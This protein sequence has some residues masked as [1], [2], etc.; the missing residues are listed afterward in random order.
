[1]VTR[2]LLSTDVFDSVPTTE[3]AFVCCVPCVRACILEFLK[4][5]LQL[6]HLWPT[7]ILFWRLT[8]SCLQVSVPVQSSGTQIRTCVYRARRASSTPRLRRATHVSLLLFWGQFNRCTALFLL[9]YY[10]RFC[11]LVIGKSV[12]ETPDVWKLAAIT[13]FSVLAVVL[14]G[15]ALIIGVM[16]HRRKS[17]KRPLRGACPIYRATHLHFIA[18]ILQPAKT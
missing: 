4:R 5:C 17:H 15:A 7:L 14:V 11:R 2:A 3:K 10:F 13:S 12:E 18:Q 16:V 9:V 6:Q 1:M 8:S